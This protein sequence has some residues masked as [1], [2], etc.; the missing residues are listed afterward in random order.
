[1]VYEPRAIAYTEAPE[2]WLQFTKQ[3]YVVVRIGD[4]PNQRRR[5]DDLAPPEVA[6]VLV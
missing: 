1:M 2:S 3:R 4:G 5:L 6:T